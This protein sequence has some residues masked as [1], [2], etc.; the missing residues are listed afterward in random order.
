MVLTNSGNGTFG[1]NAVLTVG[2]SP[3]HVIAVDLNGD[4]KRDLVC[5]NLGD[6]TLTVLLNL[7]PFPPA[8]F[9]GLGSAGSGQMGIFWP[10][11]ATNYVLE[12][13]TNLSGIWTPVTNGASIIG[14]IVSNTS[15]QSFFRLSRPSSD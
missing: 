10:A 13:S 9:L 3:I 1:S 5:V 6:N 12:S 11:G 7:T 4:G 14:V 2:A 8:P 15:P